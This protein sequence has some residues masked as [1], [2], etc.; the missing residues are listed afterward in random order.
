[1]KISKIAELAE[2]NFPLH[3]AFDGDNAGL[4]VGDSDTEVTGILV[5]CDVDMGVVEE[6]IQNK[7][8]LIV[9]HHPIMFSPI[10]RMTESVPEQKFIRKMVKNDIALYSAHTNLD[11]GRGGINDLMATMLGMEDT[12]VVDAVCED[13][14]GTHGFGRICKL[15][16]KITLKEL[17]D[18]VI[19]V[20][21]ADGLRYAG[22]PETIVE[23]VAVNT[24]GGAGILNDCIALGC[25]CL[26]T[27]DIKYNGYRDAIDGD[28]CVIDI[29]HYD[30][31]HIAKK[32]FKDYF[33][34]NGIDAPIY[35]SKSNINLIKTYTK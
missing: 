2:K 6:A 12:N 1:M 14:R 30:S 34:K 7:C 25:D 13:E 5:T 8:N 31:E 20:F 21:G 23:T 33:T 15:K 19:D 26:I 4:L 28:M 22:D 18:K 16:D 27:G 11:A 32:W 10:N 9:S 35:E 3:Y 17:M 29:M 24:G